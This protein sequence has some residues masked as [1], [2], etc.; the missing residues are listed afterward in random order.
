M[1]TIIAKLIASA[2]VVSFLVLPAGLSAKERQ[3]AAR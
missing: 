2:L 3:G 1:K